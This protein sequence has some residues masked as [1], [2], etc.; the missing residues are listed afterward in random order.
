ML[1]RPPI[2][3]RTDPLC[4]CTT[5]FRSAHAHALPGLVGEHFERSCRSAVDCAT[6]GLDLVEIEPVI[7]ADTALH[8]D[9]VGARAGDLLQDSL[10]VFRPDA[11]RES[12]EALPTRMFRRTEEHTPETQLLM[13]IEYA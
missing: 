9:P 7:G 4:P 10:H 2:S 3:T 5:L 6:D 12:Y 13:R 8:V 11:A 1:R